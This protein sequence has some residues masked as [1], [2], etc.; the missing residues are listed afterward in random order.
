MISEKLLDFDPF[1]TMYSISL[2]CLHIDFLITPEVYPHSSHEGS[3]RNLYSKLK[4]I[5]IVDFVRTGV[6]SLTL[7]AGIHFPE[8]SLI[9]RTAS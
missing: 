5:G 6:L 4:S 3:I 9:T 1:L 8:V 2:H 7:L